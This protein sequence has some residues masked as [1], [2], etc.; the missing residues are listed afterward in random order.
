[1]YNVSSNFQYAKLRVLKKSDV[2]NQAATTLPYQ[3]IGS[4]AVEA[5]ECGWHAGGFAGA[6]PSARHAHQRI[7]GIVCQCH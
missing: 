2:Y 7:G 3:E 6:D 4:A 1:M 5:E